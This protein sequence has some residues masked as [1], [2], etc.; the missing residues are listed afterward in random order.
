MMRSVT[1][2]LAPSAEDPPMSNDLATTSLL[3]TNLAAEEGHPTLVRLTTEALTLA[4]IPPGDL[5]NVAAAVKRGEEVAGQVI[6]LSCVACAEGDADEA[7]LTVSYRTGPSKTESA[8]IPFADAAQRE[9]F[10]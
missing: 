5:G 3:W 10:L 2:D 9:E 7:E 4:T 1:P 8:T 6:P